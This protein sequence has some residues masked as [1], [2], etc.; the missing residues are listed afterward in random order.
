MDSNG[1]EKK[2]K[3]I[4]TRQKKKKFYF[5][6]IVVIAAFG[7]GGDLVYRR[8]RLIK[9]KSVSTDFLSNL[10]PNKTIFYTHIAS[11]A[12]GLYN[13][14]TYICIVRINRFPPKTSLHQRI[15]ILYIV[16]SVV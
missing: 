8:F 2:S 16:C 10:S 1:I 6:A 4:R 15:Y 9:S 12:A 13:V 7:G 14:C 3:T 11:A 5:F